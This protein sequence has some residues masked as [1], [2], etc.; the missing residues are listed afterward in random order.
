MPCECINK[1]LDEL[2]AVALQ[3]INAKHTGY[4]VRT[5][6]ESKPLP[7]VDGIEGGLVMRA[8]TQAR[9][10]RGSSQ[11]PDTPLQITTRTPINYCPFCGE[12]LE[13][14]NNG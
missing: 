5:Q 12:K 1:Q 4:S 2:H 14:Q 3:Q 6:W 10:V 13:Q 7:L 11:Y 8:V 9:R